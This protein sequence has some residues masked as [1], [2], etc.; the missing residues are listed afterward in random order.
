MDFT[1]DLVNPNKEQ[2][3]IEKMFELSNST[4]ES[5]PCSISKIEIQ[6]NIENIR[7]PIAKNTFPTCMEDDYSMGL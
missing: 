4:K 1:G 5:D 6:N 2:S 7:V 3:D